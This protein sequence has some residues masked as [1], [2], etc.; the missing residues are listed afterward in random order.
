MSLNKI[1]NNYDNNLEIKNL[2]INNRLIL[3]ST[4]S[5]N[6]SNGTNG[7]VL[8]ST[9]SGITWATIPLLNNANIFTVAPQTISIDSA[10][11]I[12]LIVKGS[13]SQT[14]DL[15]QTQTF[16]GVNF[17]IG[18]NGVVANG[19]GTATQGAPTIAS[20]TTIAPV[21][22]IVFVSGTTA[23][24][25]ITAPAPISTYGGTITI[26]PTGLWATTTAGNIS[27]ASTA[28]VNRAIQFTYD[29]ATAKWY[30]SY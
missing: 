9:G 21:N 3:N 16:A 25:T 23:I 7:Q 17:A 24:A 20:A 5:L 12:G 8:Q 18:A 4:L 10:G 1:N 11:N 13:T 28:V 19:N 2:L 14:A 27:L 29:V 15:L 26:I 30:P 6:G 22:P